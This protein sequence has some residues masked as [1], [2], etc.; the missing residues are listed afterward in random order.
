MMDGRRRATVSLFAP[1]GFLSLKLDI[2]SINASLVAAGNTL[3]K[4]GVCHQYCDLQQYLSEADRSG[5]AK[6]GGSMS[7]DIWRV[8][9]THLPK[10]ASIEELLVTDV[11][12]ALRIWEVRQTQI[13]A[14]AQSDKTFVAHIAR[15]WLNLYLA[16]RDHRFLNATLKSV[17]ALVMAGWHDGILIENIERIVQTL[18]ALP[19]KQDQQA[20]TVR[21]KR[22]NAVKPDR[23]LSIVVLSGPHTSFTEVILAGLS[24]SGL[25]PKSI[26]VERADRL[27]HVYGD[28]YHFRVG[29]NFYE[30]YQNDPGPWYRPSGRSA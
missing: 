16:G 8:R 13:R 22:M 26:I 25:R 11:E 15:E 1:F 12:E 27:A 24:K 21:L 7:S 5:R 28:Y 2:K 17:D 19:E 14:R 20:S 3:Y 29:D 10:A 23:E 30:R 9:M 18:S 6:M 4:S